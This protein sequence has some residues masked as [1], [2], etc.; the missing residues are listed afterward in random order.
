M[1]WNTEATAWKGT[2]YRFASVDYASRDDLITGQG[3]MNHA[4]RWNPK[5]QFPAVYTSLTPETALA[6]TRAHYDY[7]QF[8]FADATPT[9]LTS[10][11][12]MLS[13]VLDLSQGPI[14]TKLRISLKRMQQEDWRLLNR[15]SQISLTQALGQKLFEVGFEAIVVPSFA[16]S[17]FQN[18]VIFPGNRR[19]RSVVAIENAHKLPAKREE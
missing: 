7:Y 4:G 8:D 6:E 14:R 19:P 11:H 16:H 15:G 1:D 17:G 2:V 12:V 5:G 10:L 13:H 18:L 9:V 3:A